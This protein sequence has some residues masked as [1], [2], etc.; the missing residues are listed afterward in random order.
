MAVLMTNKAWRHNRGQKESF[1]SPRF[2]HA[3]A[4]VGDDV[5]HMWGKR[6]QMF[7]GW[8]Q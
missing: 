3:K 7:D 6:K 1:N 2:V 5:N 8:Y 4:T